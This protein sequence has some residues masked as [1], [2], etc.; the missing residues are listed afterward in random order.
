MSSI[1]SALVHSA[2]RVHFL[3]VMIWFLFSFIWSAYSCISLPF[4][5]VVHFN[6]IHCLLSAP[7][8][9][10]AQL[11]YVR[12][13]Y[14]VLHDLNLVLVHLII[15]LC[16]SLPFRSVFH[17]HV[18][19]IVHHILQAPSIRFLFSI[20]L[21]II[22]YV[23]RAIS[24]LSIFKFSIFQ[25][26]F[27]N[28]HWPIQKTTIAVK[29]CCLA[30]VSLTSPTYFTNTHLNILSTQDSQVRTSCILSDFSFVIRRSFLCQDY[31]F[32][33][34]YYRLINWAWWEQVKARLQMPI[35]MLS[36]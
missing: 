28:S 36:D 33:R 6:V 21:S 27:H 7:T 10:D 13:H 24:W 8:H 5:S 9:Y 26:S 20:F 1:I 18:F 16:V 2:I 15:I 23:S 29:S 14:L 17:F 31:K 3:V 35:P 25:F 32:A 4:Y 12:V 22:L 30:Q 34:I 11:C 19:I